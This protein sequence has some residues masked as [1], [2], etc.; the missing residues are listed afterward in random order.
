VIADAVAADDG[1]GRLERVPVLGKTVVNTLRQSI[2][3]IVYRVFERTIRDIS[4]TED[5]RLVDE[6]VTVIV[7]SILEEHPELGDIGTRMTLEAIELIKERVRV[8]HWKDALDRRHERG[9]QF[10]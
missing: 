5:N 6:M 9:A 1:I 2:N 7:D 3:D 8:Q 4:A 10:A